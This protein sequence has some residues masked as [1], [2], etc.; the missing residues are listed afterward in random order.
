MAKKR[1]HTVKDVAKIKEME[2]SLNASARDLRKIMDDVAF[3]GVGRYRI[4]KS[5]IEHIPIA[6]GEAKGGTGPGG[7]D[8]PGGVQ[9]G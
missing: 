4:T 1:Y 7:E 8:A 2:V 6:Y 9:A 5:K 3:Y